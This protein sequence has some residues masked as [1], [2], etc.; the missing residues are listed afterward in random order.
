MCV[1]IYTYKKAHY[2]FKQQNPRYT[3]IKQ[4]QRTNFHLRRFEKGVKKQ[5]FYAE[6]ILISVKKKID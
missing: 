6:I 4:F 1:Y 2:A 5:H 3:F